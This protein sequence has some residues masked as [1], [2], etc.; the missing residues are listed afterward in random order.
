MSWG[1]GEGE[2]KGERSKL[3]TEPGSLTLES[4]SQPWDHD[5]SQ[6]QQSTLLNWLSHLG[7]KDICVLMLIAALGIS[8]K[9]SWVSRTW[10][11][12]VTINVKVGHQQPWKNIYIYK[13]SQKLHL[14]LT[15][16][17]WVAERQVGP[18]RTSEQEGLRVAAQYD[19]MWHAACGDTLQQEEWSS[20]RKNSS[21]LGGNGSSDQSGSLWGQ[22]PLSQVSSTTEEM[23]T[24]M[25]VFIFW[26]LSPVSY[27]MK[28]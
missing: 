28:F 3:P 5:Q 24:K 9:T 6:N 25:R 14:K 7:P 12:L 4:I 10:S 26:T 15:I 11:W 8:L 13:V 18:K 2:G 27:E 17:L 19:Q 20:Q 22:C 1:R 21:S 23:G 16:I